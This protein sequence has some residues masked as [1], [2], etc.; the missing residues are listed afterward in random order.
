MAAVALAAALGVAGWLL[1]RALD[2]QARE[3]G[4]RVLRLPWRRKARL[5]WGLVRDARI[6]LW[7]RGIIPV[8]VIYLALP[9]DVIPDFIPVLGYLDDLLIVAV[10]GAL[11]IRF[12]PRAV[13]EDHLAALESG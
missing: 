10:A 1:V 5:S 7:T 12:V 9:V 4:R 6:P 13:I 8:L 3:I 2:D 11:L